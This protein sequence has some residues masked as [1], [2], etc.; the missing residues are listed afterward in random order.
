MSRSAAPARE[1]AGRG[2]RAGTGR[3][4]A[5]AAAV[6]VAVGLAVGS[7]TS[8]AQTVLGGSALAGLANAVSP[9]VVAPFLLGA[10]ARSRRAA[11][12]LGVL[13]GVAEVAGYYLTAALRGFAVSPTFVAVWAV[14]GILAGIV[15]GIA[16]HSWRTGSGRER[17]AG[18]ALLVAAWA[19]EA[20]VT[21]G[22]VLGYLDDAVVFGVV[23][24]L[25]FLV[26]GRHRRQHAAVAA[27]LVPGLVL[28]VL[29]TLAVHAVL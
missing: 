2:D 7:A 11:A 29:G 6:A 9:W 26:L 28:G 27:W 19:C 1:R 18:A 10:Q 13:T 14:A 15:F 3:G 21:F 22:V 12:G 5:A 20:L 25:L 4:V 16:G 8:G 17:G 24:V 23:A